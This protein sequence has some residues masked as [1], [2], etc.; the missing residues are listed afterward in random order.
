MSSPKASEY[1]PS[2]GEQ[3]QSQVARAQ[4]DEWNKVFKPVEDRFVADT[5]R[6]ITSTVTGR[7]NADVAQA[8]N[9]ASEGSLYNQTSRMSDVPSLWN[10]AMVSQNLAANKAGGALESGMMSDALEAVTNRSGTLSKNIA[11]GADIGRTNVLTD[12]RNKLAVRNSYLNAGAN[13]LGT[14]GMNT[15]KNIQGGG[16]GFSPNKNA[17]RMGQLDL[18]AMRDAPADYGYALGQIPPLTF[19]QDLA[20]GFGDRLRAVGNRSLSRGRTR[21]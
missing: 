16:T 3:L 12:A 10:A 7:A 20:T 18:A 21:R 6:D 1:A 13:V 14:L 8:M 17:G 5:Q 9:E 4:Y 11:A 2:P 19:K 15:I